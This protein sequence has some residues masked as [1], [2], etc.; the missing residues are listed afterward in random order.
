MIYSL[1]IQVSVNTPWYTSFTI[2][3]KKFSSPTDR[4]DL[5]TMIEAH[6][7]CHQIKLLLDT[8][9]N[10]DLMK[11]LNTTLTI[12]Y[13]NFS[14]CIT[15]SVIHPRSL[16]FL[17][18]H[19]RLP[20]LPQI[21]GGKVFVL[22]FSSMN[23]VDLGST[24]STIASRLKLW[25]STPLFGFHTDTDIGHWIGCLDLA[26]NIGSD[27]YA[28]TVVEPSKLH[29]IAFLLV[30]FASRTISDKPSN[31]EFVKIGIARPKTVL[32]DCE[33]LPNDIMNLLN[34]GLQ[35]VPKRNKFF[36]D[37]IARQ[38]S[39]NYNLPNQWITDL[40]DNLKSLAKQSRPEFARHCSFKL[41]SEL[42]DLSRRYVIKPADK[43]GRVV[44]MSKNFYSKGVLSL[45]DTP[46][47][48]RL[49]TTRDHISMI[50]SDVISALNR[51]KSKLKSAR[52][53]N[54]PFHE[55]VTQESRIGLF[56]GLPKIHKS[57]ENPPLRPVASQINHPSAPIARS[58]DRIVQQYIYEHNPH[59]LF[60]TDHALKILKSWDCSS[61]KLISFDVKSL[62]T[63]IPL[64]DGLEA[65]RTESSLWDMKEDHN[66]FVN[67]LA[68]LILHNNVFKFQES[69]FLQRKGVASVFSTKEMCRKI[70]ALD[71]IKYYVRY[72]DD[73]LIL[74][75]LSVNENLLNESM[76]HLHDS[77]KFELVEYGKSVDFLDLTLVI[78]NSLLETVL[79][80]KNIASW[81]KYIDRSSLHDRGMLGG[82]AIGAFKRA[83]K[84]CSHPYSSAHYIANTTI[85]RLRNRGLS[86]NA[87]TLA[88][89]RS[90]RTKIKKRENLI[91]I[92]VNS[93][94][95]T[96]STRKVLNEWQDRINAKMP[97]QK[98]FKVQLVQKNLMN[99][100]KF[101]IRA[102]SDI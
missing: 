12:H 7:N 80:E 75:D 11:E 91:R 34:K 92:V 76:N 84:Y 60:S 29:T 63:S 54:S 5:D 100:S 56:Y 85:P 88:L 20:V 48:M 16:K 58:V 62:Y 97:P 1:G 40:M 99:L 74:S 41:L 47:Y 89:G 26:C 13:D 17:V 8:T 19:S 68:P 38:V 90:M 32:I 61:A 10:L 101:C 73:I 98:M 53:C 44:V 2:L 95:S 45:L 64:D 22:D 93:H 102:D 21:K 67:D 24:M 46:D 78:K 30:H 39:V 6:N 18:S 55:T 14:N 9:D 36:I 23:F 31:F 27:G 57:L 65:L 87:V 83:I 51:L 15:T 82:V 25:K 37:D 52:I 77:I 94:S 42:R 70:M 50:K 43:G 66:T 96:E 4:S 33:P 35:F 72:I 71:G 49:P 69:V 81:D 79:Y 59:L 28:V 3:R 86:R